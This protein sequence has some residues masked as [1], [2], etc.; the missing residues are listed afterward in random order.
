MAHRAYKR[1]AE[2]LP[3]GKIE[4]SLPL[5]P[6]TRVEVVVLAE[7]ED[8]ADLLDAAASST[9]FWDNPRDDAEWNNA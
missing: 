5:P 2:V 7:E 4:V 1:S 8:W 6:G 9:G 3:G